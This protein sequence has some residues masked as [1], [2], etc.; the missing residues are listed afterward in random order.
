[1]TISKVE[2]NRLANLGFV[3]NSHIK[4]LTTLNNYEHEWAIEWLPTTDTAKNEENLS[5]FMHDQLD[6]TQLKAKRKP[7]EDSECEFDRSGSRQK[8][9][10]KVFPVS[11]VSTI[12]K[13]NQI[14]NVMS[15]P[16]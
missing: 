14:S 10:H 5:E 3:E 13:P 11:I 2:Q 1:L 6:F 8:W 4:E 7:E 16:N 15:H 12:A 9:L